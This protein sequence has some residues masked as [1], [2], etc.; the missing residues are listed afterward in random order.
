MTKTGVVIAE[1]DFTASLLFLTGEF[2]LRSASFAM[3]KLVNEL[4]F[5]IFVMFGLE[6]FWIYVKTCGLQA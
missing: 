1:F 2:S 5:G 6:K 4:I 3:R